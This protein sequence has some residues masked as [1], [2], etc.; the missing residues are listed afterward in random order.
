[1]GKNNNKSSSKRAVPV[2]TPSKTVQKTVIENSSSDE[3]DAYNKTG[4]NVAKS[5]NHPSKRGTSTKDDM[6]EVFA[7]TPSK[8]LNPAAPVFSSA[9]SS[10]NGNAV[11][12]E[13]TV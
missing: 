3:S 9:V 6:D 2:H 8:P 4:S 5:S 1:M 11:N 12:P 7:E 10:N 13:I